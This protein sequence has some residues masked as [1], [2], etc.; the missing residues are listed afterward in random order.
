MT[1][2]QILGLGLQASI[3]LTVFGFALGSTFR[4]ANYLFRHPA[5]LL[6]CVL[7]MMVVMPLIVLA[8]VLS[9]DLPFEVKVALVAIS[10]S[11]VPP[12]LQKNQIGAGGPLDFV[13]GLLVAMSALAIVVVPLWVWI[14]DQVFPL[15]QAA[16]AYDRL[17]E[18]GKYGKVLVNVGE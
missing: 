10:I 16:A 9:L 8:I 14:I 13:T 11:P 6:R 15:D 1:A 2:E 3:V 7:S 12:I 18:S 4:D 17:A 5:L